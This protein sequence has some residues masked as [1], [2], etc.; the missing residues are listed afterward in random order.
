MR[1][2]GLKL[3]EEGGG[4]GVRKRKFWCKVT[5]RSPEREKSRQKRVS[6]EWKEAVKNGKKGNAGTN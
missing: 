2:G 1:D 6:V 3:E 4:E 5:K